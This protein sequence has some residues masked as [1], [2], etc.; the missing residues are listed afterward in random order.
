MSRSPGHLEHPEHQVRETRVKGE[1]KVTLD[2]RLIARCS[3]VIRVDQDGA[4]PRYYFPR[5][6]VYVDQLDRSET[7]TACPYK[8]QATYYSITHAGRHLNDAIWSYEAPYDEH[9]A[10]K[11]RMAFYDTRHSSI[12]VSA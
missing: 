8:G 9:A 3:D 1:V 12:V 10:L 11:G 2:G 5:D 4:P 7:T 6:A